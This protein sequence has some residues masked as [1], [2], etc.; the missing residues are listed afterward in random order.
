MVIMIQKS[1]LNITEQE[2]LK[3]QKT[4]KGIGNLFRQYS[5]YRLMKR[6]EEEYNF[7]SSVE[8]PYDEA[9][10]GIDGN[11]FSHSHEAH[12]TLNSLSKKSFDF[13]WNFGFL[14]RQPSLIW[15]MKKISKKYIAAFVPNYSN[16]GTL[17]HKLYHLIYKKPCNHPERG[18]PRLMSMNGLRKLFE[19]V[20]F[21]VLE[22]GYVDIPPFPDTVVTIK[23]FFGSGGRN[24]LKI[25]INVKKLLPFEHILFPKFI[26]AHHC[27][28]FA[29]K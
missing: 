8:V 2:I 16:P 29:E 23:E 28:V 12:R 6:W 11:I 24:A 9:T 4:F 17:I 3:W 10:D 22:V 20:G 18:D 19:N 26:F 25:P 7:S 13:V 27:Y 21:N 15:K 5:Q 1:Y 14:Q